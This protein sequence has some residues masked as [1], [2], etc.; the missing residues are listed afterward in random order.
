MGGEGGLA[1]AAVP[2]LAIL[3]LHRNRVTLRVVQHFDGNPYVLAHRAKG[4]KPTRSA[5][6]TPTR[7]LHYSIQADILLFLNA[8]ESVR[9]RFQTHP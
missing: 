6:S 7:S 4:A 3:E 5:P 9:Q 1:Q 8:K 2:N